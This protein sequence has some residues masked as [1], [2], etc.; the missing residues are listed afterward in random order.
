LSPDHLGN[1]ASLF[2]VVQAES[3]LPDGTHRTY[4][5]SFEPFEGKLIG[6]S[7]ILEPK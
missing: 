1:F 7:Q 5:F 3:I 2:W 4:G 6:L